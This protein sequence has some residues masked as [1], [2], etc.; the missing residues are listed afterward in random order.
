M[1]YIWG[2]NCEQGRDKELQDWYVKNK[3]ILQKEVPKGVKFVGI[4]APGMGIGSRDLY[5]VHEIGSYGDLDRIRDWQT[6]EA[7]RVWGELADFA[8]PG[9]GETMILREAGDWVIPPKKKPE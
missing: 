6:P 3:K 2:V 1:L 5:I 7:M 9:G 4:F 8:A